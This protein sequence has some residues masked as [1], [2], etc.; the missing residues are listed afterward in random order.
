MS[1]TT[2]PATRIDFLDDV[3]ALAMISVYLAHILERLDSVGFKST[4]L[5]WQFIC[6]VTVPLFFFVSGLVAKRNDKPLTE[7]LQTRVKRCV[8]PVLFFS[9]LM[10]PFWIL[11]GKS[12]VELVTMAKMYLYGSPHFHWIMWYLIA[13]FWIELMCAGLFALFGARPMLSWLWSGIFIIAGAFITP[14]IVDFNTHNGLPREFWF[15]AESF[16]GAAFYFAGHAAKPWLVTLPRNVL[17]GVA[18]AL[19]LSLA[20]W[21][22]PKI[23]VTLFRVVI[24]S[25]SIHGHYPWFIT[26]AFA[27]IV[28]VLLLTRVLP[29]GIRALQ[30]IGRNTLIYL[31]LNGLCFHFIDIQFARTLLAIPDQWYLILPVALAYIAAMFALFTPVVMLIGR[32]CRPLLGM[33]N[34]KARS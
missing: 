22:T 4:L 26:T 10:L 9:V 14:A 2:H 5:L 33:S 27:G 7:F 16:V 23:D 28:A 3:R 20:F 12:T 32:Y 6:A 30:F 34:S 24:T 29:P 15:I 21:L 25:Y 1:T 11:Q 13:I 18:G 31:G 17:I 19:M 8:M